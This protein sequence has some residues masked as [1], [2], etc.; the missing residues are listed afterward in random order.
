VAVGEE[1]IQDGEHELARL[2]LYVEPTSA[3]VWPAVLGA[4]SR[5]ADPVVV[6]LTGS[7]YKHSI[8]ESRA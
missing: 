2:G 7:G 3:V 4:L 8:G 6:V 1:D 5:L